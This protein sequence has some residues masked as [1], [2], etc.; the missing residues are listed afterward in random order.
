MAKAKSQTVASGKVDPTV[1]AGYNKANSGYQE[2]GTVAA[3]R[4]YLN[5]V[6][7]SKPKPFASTYEGQLSSIYDRIM[8]RDP[9]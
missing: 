2:G 8:N 5:G 3:A 4:N 7:N 6:L 9:F 1:Q